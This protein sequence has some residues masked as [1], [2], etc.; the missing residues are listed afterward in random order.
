MNDDQTAVIRI[1]PCGMPRHSTCL[2]RAAIAAC[3]ITPPAAPVAAHAA[4][5]P[6]PHLH[7]KLP[8][9]CGYVQPEPA[10]EPAPHL[11]GTPVLNQHVRRGIGG[12][13]H[14]RLLCREACQQPCLH[15]VCW[16]TKGVSTAVDKQHEPH[17][18]PVCS[19]TWTAPTRRTNKN[20]KVL[21][22]MHSCLGAMQKLV[23][24]AAVGPCTAP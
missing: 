13:A 24:W 19:S 18:F 2:L 9:A 15:W 14:T 21:R 12:V 6:A 22:P 1:Q 4:A 17:R 7:V 23:L 16:Q 20:G 5:G 8:V 3:D 10:V 11:V